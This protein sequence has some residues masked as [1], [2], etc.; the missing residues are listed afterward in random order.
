MYEREFKE[1]YVDGH[2]LG[3]TKV[4]FECTQECDDCPMSTVCDTLSEGQHYDTFIANYKLLK[5][6][7]TFVKIIEEV[8][9]A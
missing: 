4:E 7:E 8:D 2:I 3:L 6:G 5:L 9:N 1:A